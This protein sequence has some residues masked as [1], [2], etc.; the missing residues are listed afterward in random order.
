MKLAKLILLPLIALSLSS[1]GEAVRE[2]YRSDEY[3]TSDFNSNYYTSWNGVE[4]IVPIEEINHNVNPTIHDKRTAKIEGLRTWYNDDGAVVGDQYDSKG[5][6]YSWLDDDPE[7]KKTVPVGYGPNKCLSS[8]DKSFSYGYVSKL[9]DGRVR[10]D[11]FYAKSRV[12][13]N[14]T[15][16]ATYFPKALSTYK[17]FA[18]A[19]RGGT[20]CERSFSVMPKLD[21]KVSFYVHDPI[22]NTYKKHIFN[23]NDI[24][25]QT[26]A[27]GNT[28]LVSFY[29]DSVL[30]STWQSELKDTTAMSFE[31]S[32]KS[33]QYD[34]ITDDMNDK[35]KH[36]FAVML[37]EVML[38]ESTWY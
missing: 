2:L 28:S 14:K 30:G 35:E 1:C 26:N 25:V 8:I 19:L 34:D 37:Y 6:I 12:Q 23:M 18:F 20:T 22:A 10:C 7:T 17:Y 5:A 31:Y 33:I 38:P 21:I 3:I 29:F 15:G 13:L 11:G 36:H 32:V 27:G 4:S 16:Y 9:Y 24:E